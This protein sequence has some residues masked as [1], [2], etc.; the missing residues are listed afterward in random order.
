M[1]PLVSIITPSYNQGKYIRETIESV[2]N[3]DYKNIEYIIIDGGSTDETLGILSEYKNQIIFISEKDKGQSDAINKGFKLAKGEILA[4]LNSDDRY[5][6]DAISTAVSIFESHPEIGLLYGQGNIIDKNSHFVKRFEYTHSFDL[7][8]LIFVWDYI[9]Q[10]TTFFKANALKEVNYLDINLNWTMDWDLWIRLSLQNEV[11]FV[12]KVLASSREYSDTKT[13]MGGTER[14]KE[15][16]YILNKYSGEEETYGYRIYYHSEMV[17]QN[18]G[19]ANLVAKH[20][21]VLEKLIQEIPVP[22][23]YQQDQCNSIV[24]FAVRIDKKDYYLRVI[25]TVDA[26]IELKILINKKSYTQILLPKK[27]EYYIKVL[28]KNIREKFNLIES[29]IKIGNSDLMQKQNNNSLQM[30]LCSDIKNTKNIIIPKMVNLYPWNKRKYLNQLYGEKI[31][32]PLSVLP[33]N[34]IETIINFGI[35]GNYQLVD[36]ID[37]HEHEVTGV[38]SSDD[39]R[40]KF[41]IDSKQNFSV[42][43]KFLKLQENIQLQLEYGGVKLKNIVENGENE[44]EFDLKK[45]MHIKGQ[46]EQELRFIVAKATSPLLLGCG[47]DKRILGIHL[48]EM[49]IKK[50]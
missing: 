44:W 2:L 16:K 10:P 1:E 7:W 25:I 31:K 37:W 27:G 28:F 32:E 20:N 18:L 26:V 42:K 35:D 36:L 4:W 14:L 12:D 48:I 5:E 29:H 33:I 22:N 24:N 9:M 43:I 23:H 49:I 6:L 40:I 47:D 34:K 39:S 8:E 38:W 21:N 11:Y 19:N 50:Y 30:K 41:C 3:Q 15:I 13:S 45:E 17:Q 46:K